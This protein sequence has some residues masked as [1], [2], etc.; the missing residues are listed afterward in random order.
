MI[1][2]KLTNDQLDYIA[3][4]IIDNY[5]EMRMKAQIY[6]D[7]KNESV[8]CSNW[9]DNTKTE[10]PLSGYC[11]GEIIFECCDGVID[12]KK[13]DEENVLTEFDKED[14]LE[15]VYNTFGTITID[16]EKNNVC[17]KCREYIDPDYD[18]KYFVEDSEGE[19]KNVC[20]ICVYDYLEDGYVTD[21]G[22]MVLIPIQKLITNNENGLIHVKIPDYDKEEWIELDYDGLAK[23]KKMNR[24]EITGDD[25]SISTKAFEIVKNFC[26]EINGYICG[27]IKN[28]YPSYYSELLC[29]TKQALWDRKKELLQISK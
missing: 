14:I 29:I 27:N 5:W 13:D 26:N 11:L 22:R 24:S 19:F 23:I 25:Y 20:E 1:K 4:W 21:I 18:E 7:L 12:E 15:F 8:R 9:Y 6:Y 28:L 16:V 10:Y 17:Q 2:R 3:N